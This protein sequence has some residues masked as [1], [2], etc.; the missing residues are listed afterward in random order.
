MLLGAVDMHAPSADDTHV[1]LT[2]LSEGF[3]GLEPFE[4]NMAAQ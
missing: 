3:I 1:L 2:L 4:Q